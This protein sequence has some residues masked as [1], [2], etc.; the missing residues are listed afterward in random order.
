MGKRSGTPDHD[1]DLEKLTLAELDTAIAQC[2]LRLDFARTSYLKKAF[3]RRLT[4]LEGFREERH[5]VSAPKRVRRARQ[6]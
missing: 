3:F 2:K 1:E 4:W 5:G 6:K